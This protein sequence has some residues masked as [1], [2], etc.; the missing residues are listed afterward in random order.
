MARGI[1][2]KDVQTVINFDVPPSAAAYLHR[3]GRTGRAGKRGSAVTL[4]SPGE[5]DALESVRE[6]LALAG[7]APGRRRRKV[8]SS[9]SRS[10]APST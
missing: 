5:E 1:D 2:F 4:V 10:S 9:L 8:Y 6:T 3:V 7:A